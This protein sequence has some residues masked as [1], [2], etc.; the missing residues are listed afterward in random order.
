MYR[1]FKIRK[2]YVL[3]SQCIYVFCVDLTTNSDYFHIEQHL[4]DIYIQILN[5]YTSVVTMCTTC[6]CFSYSNYYQLSVL[7]CFVWI[8]E[9][10]AI[11]SLY[12]IKWLV[13]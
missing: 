2:F 12:N 1:Q 11:I 7:L 8:W 6:L 5:F 13:L 4:T 10:T 3:A 9:Q